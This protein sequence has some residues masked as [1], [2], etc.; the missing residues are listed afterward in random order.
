MYELTIMYAFLVLKLTVDRMA[1]Q[2]D[3]EQ[4]GM[5]LVYARSDPLVIMLI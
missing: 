2:V 3:G 5:L 4:Q 1:S